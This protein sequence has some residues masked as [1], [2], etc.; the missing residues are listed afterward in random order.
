MRGQLRDV[1]LRDGLQL[2]GKALPTSFKLEIVRELLLLGVPQLEVGSLARA[3]LVPSMANTLDVVGALSSDELSRCWIWVATPRHVQRALDAGAQNVQYCLSASD[4]HNIANIAR[5]THASLAALPD[6]V[7]LVQAVAGARIQLCIATSFTCPF[8][9]VIQPSRVLAVSGDARTSGVDEVVVCDTLGQ[10]I[11]A[12]VEHLVRALR[13]QNPDRPVV[14]HGHDTWGQGVANSQAA[15]AA[16]A[17][18]IDGSLGGLGGCPFAPGAS[19]NTSTEDLVFSMRPEWLTPATLHRLV[20]I[21]ETL[22]RRLDEPNRSRAAQ[23]VRSNATAFEWTTGK[24]TQSGSPVL[25]GD[26]FVGQQI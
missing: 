14:F 9:G 11:P 17:Q 24:H 21:T 19:G 23:G 7:D 16:G 10:A 25:A 26:C 3:D 13:T 4:R 6:A 8:E 20:D 22:L 1:T 15:L 2:T 12:Q 18:T 5:P